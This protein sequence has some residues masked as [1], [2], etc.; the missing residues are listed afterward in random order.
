V[1]GIDFKTAAELPN[2]PRFL[3]GII[4]STNIVTNADEM[5]RFS[6]SGSTTSES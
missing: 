5:S 2:D 1:I 4:P 6:T 3:T